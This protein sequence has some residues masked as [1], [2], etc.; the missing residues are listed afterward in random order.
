MCPY[1]LN[2]SAVVPQAV[3][4]DAL[5]DG[6]HVVVCTAT[7]SGKSLCYNLPIIDA[8]ASDPA[9]CALYL[10]P[11]KA[12]AQDQRQALARMLAHAFGQDAPSVEVGAAGCNAHAGT[13]GWAGCAVSGGRCDKAWT[14]GP[15]P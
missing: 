15:G 11:T 6:R 5:L 9:S 7:A 12:L 10:F 13:C 1:T 14:L 2:P 8:L 4:V 3:A